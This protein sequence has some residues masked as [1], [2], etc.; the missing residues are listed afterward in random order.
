LRGELFLSRNNSPPTNYNP[1][2]IS[3]FVARSFS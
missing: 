1:M 3:V 2:N